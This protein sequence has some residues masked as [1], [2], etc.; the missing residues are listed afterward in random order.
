MWEVIFD[1]Y[2]DM[3]AGNDAFRF[4][5]EQEALAKMEECKMQVDLLM[6]GR[7]GN[8]VVDEPHFYGIMCHESGSYA[9]TFI[10]APGE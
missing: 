3:Q 6:T 8:E 10:N 1:F 2:D 4:A 9:R 5:T 7:E